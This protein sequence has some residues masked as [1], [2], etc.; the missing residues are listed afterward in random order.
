MKTRHNASLSEQVQNGEYNNGR[1]RGQIDTSS[2]RTRES[3]LYWIGTG[4]SITNVAVL[5]LAEP[6]N[7]FS[8]ARK[9][10]GVSSV[11]VKNIGWY[12]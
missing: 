3:L 1:N 4:T 7:C 2:T 11:V 10:N 12:A 8:H 5:N 9:I 6:C